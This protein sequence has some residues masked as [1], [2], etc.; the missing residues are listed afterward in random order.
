MDHAL[1]KHTN[2]F[3]SAQFC[4]LSFKSVRSVR[5]FFVVTQNK[6]FHLDYLCPI[7]KGKGKVRVMAVFIHS[8]IEFI[9]L[10]YG[11]N[12]LE[13]AQP[14]LFESACYLSQYLNSL[15]LLRIGCNIDLLKHSFVFSM[16]KQDERVKK[17]QMAAPRS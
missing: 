17:Q 16:V 5:S 10:L 12:L 8:W 3:V 1:A 4:N 11:Q 15:S 14:K 6:S 7:Y 2:K 9:K 13:G